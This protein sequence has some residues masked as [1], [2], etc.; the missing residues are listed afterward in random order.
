[1]IE[2]FPLLGLWLLGLIPG[3][4]L[5][6]FACALWLNFGEWMGWTRRNCFTGRVIG[7]KDGSRRR[8]L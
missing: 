2:T 4:W 6:W 1:M 5:G 7:P 8:P 3:L